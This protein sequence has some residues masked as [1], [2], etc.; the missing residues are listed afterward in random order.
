MNERDREGDNLSKSKSKWE[1][2]GITINFNLY[3]N[4]TRCKP[5]SADL[6]IQ[7]NIIYDS[8]IL[9]LLF[10]FLTYI[11]KKQ[12]FLFLN[13]LKTQNLWNFDWR[14][15]LDIRSNSNIIK[16]EF[17]LATKL[18][19]VFVQELPKSFEI[20]W[21]LLSNIVLTFQMVLGFR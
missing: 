15:I 14:L 13:E 8:T 17:N 2:R 20:L 1:K 7:L 6:I 19:A 11:W 4:E 12:C 3:S 16:L 5:L 21:Q 9:D 18:Y 10:I